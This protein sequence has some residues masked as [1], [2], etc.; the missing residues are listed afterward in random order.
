LPAH[1]C[2]AHIPDSRLGLQGAVESDYCPHFTGGVP[3][4]LRFR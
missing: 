4:I 1:K 2:W 3:S